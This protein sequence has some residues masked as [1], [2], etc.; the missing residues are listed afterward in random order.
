MSSTLNDAERMG[1]RAVN[2]AERH[3]S[4]LADDAHEELRAL[5][6][7]VESLMDARVT[8]AVARVADQAEEAAI[9]AQ[10]AVRDRVER[11]SEAVRE[12]PLTALGAAALAGFVA[13]LLFKR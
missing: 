9:Y 12:Q 5:R 7:K 1:R 10:D 8:P 11:L 4:R 2:E 6:A 13:A 3:A